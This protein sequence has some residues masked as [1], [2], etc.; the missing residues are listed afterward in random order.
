MPRTH[1]RE[2]RPETSHILSLLLSIITIGCEISAEPIAQGADK[3]LGNIVQGAIPSNFDAYWNQVTVENGAKWGMVETSRDRMDWDAISTAYDYAKSKDFPY[4]QHTF[5]WGTQ[6]PGWIS[7]ITAAQQ[8]KEVEDWIKAYGEKFPETEFIDVV[9]EPLNKPP[10]FKNALGGD[11]ATGWDWVVTVFEMARGHC[12]NARLLIN[13]FEVEY[14]VKLAAA[15][16]KIAL[17]LKEKGLVDGI[18][19]QCHTN[20]IQRD[21]PSIEA[22]RGALD[23]LASSGLPL[24]VS[25]LDLKGD[26]AAQL[27]SYKRLF[28]VF[29][30]HPSVAGITLWGYQGS[31][32]NEDA[33]LIRNGAERPA[34]K[35]LRAYV[36]SMKTV[37]RAAAADKE[38]PGG[39]MRIVGMSRGRLTIAA[40]SSRNVSL[41]IADLLGRTVYRQNCIISKG[42]ATVSMPLNGAVRGTCI[43]FI[44]GEQGCVARVIAGW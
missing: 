7:G 28:P 3:F 26:D 20:E 44:V 2:I 14:D 4:K 10:S 12:P 32:W 35:W 42:T 30:E 39:G 9:N 22:I 18:G 17:I 16:L 38:L 34:M 15:Y 33:V 11:G 40:A 13:E 29:W 1:K 21:N 24:Y 27:A 23:T 43:L 31:I 19:I 36:D 6:E 41:A 8:K 25:E 37:T 5:V